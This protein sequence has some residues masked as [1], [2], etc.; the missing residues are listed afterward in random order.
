MNQ[1]PRL[2]TEEEVYYRTSETKKS[3]K[4]R[5]VG[6]EQRSISMTKDITTKFS[7]AGEFRMSVIAGMNSTGKACLMLPQPEGF[8]ESEVDVKGY[9]EASKVLEESYASQVLNEKSH[10]TASDNM[11]GACKAVV[12]IMQCMRARKPV[13]LW[14]VPP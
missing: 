14:K 2:Q 6:P 9:G 10:I 13:I 12:F 8:V 4:S 3:K 5:P 11:I 7:K 1:V